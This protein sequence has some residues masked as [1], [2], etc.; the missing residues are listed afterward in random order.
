MIS[1][2]IKLVLVAVAVSATA[3]ARER[4]KPGETFRDCANCPEMVL[5]P[6]GMSRTDARAM[7]G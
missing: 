5:I 1:R 6:A 2:V 4:L 7:L 3:S